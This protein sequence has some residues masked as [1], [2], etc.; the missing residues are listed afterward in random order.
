MRQFS[1]NTNFPPPPT[2]GSSK[3][4]RGRMNHG[5]GL[6]E[7]ELLE[8]D[9]YTDLSLSLS[10]SPLVHWERG[11]IAMGRRRRRKR[12]LPIFVIPPESPLNSGTQICNTGVIGYMDK[13]GGI[14][15][16]PGIHPKKREPCSRQL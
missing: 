5:A 9:T 7:K 12:R 1:R 2:R 3:L 6:Y 14:D 13:I 16:E 15:S 10:L 4:R 11:N 8:P